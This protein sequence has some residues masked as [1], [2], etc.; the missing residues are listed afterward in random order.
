MP[1]FWLSAEIGP[2]EVVTSRFRANSGKLFR[3]T[4]MQA[5]P[6]PVKIKAATAFQQRSGFCRCKKD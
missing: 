6:D 3:L 4:G 5:G 2:S 1:L